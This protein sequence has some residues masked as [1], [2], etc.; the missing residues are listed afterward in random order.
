M[1]EDA[2]AKP[3]FVPLIVTYPNRWKSGDE[4]YARL[5]ASVRSQWGNYLFVP[6]DVKQPEFRL[7]GVNDRTDI[8][9]LR[10]AVDA[11]NARHKAALVFSVWAFL[12]SVVALL[13]SIGVL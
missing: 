5:E 2:A 9:A 13:F 12:F 3:P 6:G 8:D 11:A 7:Q 1:S 10:R 4:S